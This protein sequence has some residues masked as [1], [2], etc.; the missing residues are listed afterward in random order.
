MPY[1]Y[2]GN[3]FSSENISTSFWSCSILYLCDMNWCSWNMAILYLWIHLCD[4]ITLPCFCKTVALVES[5]QFLKAYSASLTSSSLHKPDV[6]ALASAMPKT[7]Q[8]SNK[9]VTADMFSILFNFTLIECR[10]GASCVY[11]SSLYE[12]GS[13]LLGNDD[14]TLLLW[15]WACEY[16]TLGIQTYCLQTTSKYAS[17]KLKALAWQMRMVVLSGKNVPFISLNNWKNEL[18]S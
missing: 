17:L 18:C 1:W 4:W 7:K 2:K 5:S 12:N 10:K 13:Y 6:E 15:N 9:I 8:D 3:L 16:C 11:V 14:I